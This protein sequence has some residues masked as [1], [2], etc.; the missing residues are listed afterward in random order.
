VTTLYR[1]ATVL[2]AAHPAATALLEDA[3]LIVWVGADQDVGQAGRV[4]R[5]VD[6][7]GALVTAGFVDAHVHVTETGLQLDGL[8]LTDA[9]SVAEVLA[10]VET[11]ARAGA[12][13]LVLG[14]GW[15]ERLL[16]DRRPPTLAELDRAAPDAMVYLARVDVHSAV[17]SSALADRAGSRTLDGWD[18]NGR[19]E[20][21][22]HNAARAATREHLT[23]AARDALQLRGLR[24]A[25]AAGIVAVHE[26]SAPHIAPEADL[27]GLA[28]LAAR[29]GEPLPDVISY[30]GELVEDERG[31]RAV[32]G[33][34]EISGVRLRGLAGDL[35]AD[36]SLG[37]RTAWMR[38]DY[39]DAPGHR[40]HAYLSREQVRDHVVACTRA[41]VQAGM[42]V[43][44]D[45]AVD[46]VVAGLR[47]AA[48]EVGPAAVR[49]RRHRLEH[50]EALDAEA[51]SALADLGVTASVQPAFDAAWG[52]SGG[53]YA[54]RL[55]PYRAARL[56]PF[57][58]LAAAG[59]RIALG[60]DSPVTPFDPWAAVRAA[61]RHHVPGNR[62]RA[63]VAFA[64]HTAGGWAAAGVDRAG[65]LVP[66]A[67]ATF[68]AWDVGAATRRRGFAT[69][70][71]VADA[72]PSCVLTVSRGRRLHG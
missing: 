8:D 41:G 72:A 55:G 12:E 57:G 5:V 27:T 13:H 62:L 47:A 10:R 71:A 32:L 31:A 66:G 70:A 50:A 4:D 68:A 53:M 35:C 24:A 59:V 29:T 33:R 17:V 23:T 43:I 49:A 21:D 34:L 28:T 1:G 16:A 63:D 26:M 3:G 45:A 64:A 67:H 25:A 37:S 14:T 65:A 30:R 36:G 2:T 19:V 20:R 15:D 52:G 11:A 7:G 18:V 56:N 6:L 22:A 9:R 69:L 39:V 42:H 40:G 54:E 60:S 38:A 51:V 48:T 61:V 58:P 44:G 46:V